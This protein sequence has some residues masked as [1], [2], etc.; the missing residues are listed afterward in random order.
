MTRRWLLCAGLG[1]LALLA[2]GVLW[3]GG[4]FRAS[5]PKVSVRAVDEQIVAVM[6][7]MLESWKGTAQEVNKN[8]PRP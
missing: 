1:G 8:A 5:P 3:Q 6:R 7:G 2:V 4:R